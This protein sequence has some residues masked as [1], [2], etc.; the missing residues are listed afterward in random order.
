[1]HTREVCGKLNEATGRANT[2]FPVV[3]VDYQ[4]A[5]PF[6]RA[7]HQSTSLGR[8]WRSS[9]KLLLLPSSHPAQLFS[10]QVQ[11]EKGV[12]GVLVLGSVCPSLS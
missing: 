4:E 11:L 6:W 3:P 8:I 5:E 9:S 7:A 2:E 1:M 12:E 10:L